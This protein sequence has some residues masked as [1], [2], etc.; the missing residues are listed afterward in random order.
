MRHSLLIDDRGEVWWP[1]SP[2]LRPRHETIPPDM[3][4][5]DY[6][7]QWLGFIRIRFTLKAQRLSFRPALV[8]KA[9][10]AAA[11]FVVADFAPQRLAL[12]YDEEPASSTEFTPFAT[13]Q[14][15]IFGDYG[16]AMRRIDRLVRAA[17]VQS[18]PE[19]FARAG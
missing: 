7:V 8:T 3:D 11:Y 10:V 16:D 9:A 15:E 13:W 6:A 17:A 12:Q 1:G 5:Q 19:F 4:F 2:I 18:V 14:D